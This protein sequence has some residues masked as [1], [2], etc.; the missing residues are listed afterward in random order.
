M[1]KQHARKSRE[2]FVYGSALEALTQGL[3]PDKRHVLREFVQNAF[4]ALQELRRSHKDAS[5]TPIKVR[6][7]PPSIT[8]FDRGIGMSER[9]MREYRYLGFSQKDPALN[10]GFRG[11]GKFAGVAIAKNIIVTSTRLGSPKAH[12]VTINAEGIFNHLKS[13]P[14]AV[15]NDL[16][17]D[18]ST[19]TDRAAKPLDH[20]TMVE[21]REIRDDSKL[22]FDENNISNYL[23]RVVPVPFDPAFIHGSEISKQ[24]RANVPDYFECDLLIGSHTL[25]KPFPITATAPQ[26]MPVFESPDP[27]SAI[28]AYCW[29]VRNTKNQQFKEEEFAGLGY[30]MKNFAVGDGWYVRDEIWKTSPQF[31]FWHHGE[32]HVCD[33]GVIPSADRTMFEDNANRQRLQAALGILP[34]RLNREAAATSAIDRLDRKVR[35]AKEII[36]RRLAETQAGALDSNVRPEVLFEI[37]QVIGDI[38]KRLKRAGRTTSAAKA[39]KKGVSVLKSA[40]RLLTVIDAGRKLYDV[41]KTVKMGKEAEL[42]FNIVIETIREEFAGNI[43]VIEKLV[44]R[45]SARITERFRQASR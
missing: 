38:E 26:Y 12:E 28:L 32:I 8:I 37:R 18:H 35:D 20:Y 9:Q 13:N 27:Q 11:I 21:L 39:K 41:K 23:R 6:L 1:T 25:Y 7:E 14:N 34:Q 24:L 36:D 45:I 44:R 19:V 3:Y 22:L 17:A 30:R 42:V 2:E 16:L 33:S 29:F 10:V 40:K 15:L 5:L 4:D 31:A 43:A